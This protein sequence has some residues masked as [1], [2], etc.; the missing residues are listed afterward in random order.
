MLTYLKAYGVAEG[1]DID[2][3][4][5]G[6]CRERG[7]EAVRLGEAARL[8]FADG[9]FDLVTAL[10]VVEHLDDDRGAL[11]EMRR[12]LKPGG[13]ILVTV[14]AHR[15]LWGDQDEV[16]QHKRR[17]AAR[18]LRG[19]LDATGFEIQR[20]SYMNAL[21]FPPIAA[22]RLLRR[23]ERR[24]RPDVPQ[25]SDFRYPAPSPLNFVLGHVFAAEG[26]VLQRLDI[27]F[28][29]SIVAL[30]RKPETANL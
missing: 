6:Y 7:L 24:V 29:V 11:T 23:L 14:P 15:F 18:E 21:L 28:G 27:P 20:L 17:Y 19:A 4:A 16:N 13:Q 1:V 5:I 9:T 25:E 10:D 8:P 3:E 26:P 12:V 2:A 22:A 30:A